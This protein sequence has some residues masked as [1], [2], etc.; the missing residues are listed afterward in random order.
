MTLKKEEGTL[1]DDVLFLPLLERR[2]WEE[3]LHAFLISVY[4]P[5]KSSVILTQL[6]PHKRKTATKVEEKTENR[7]CF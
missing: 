2:F 3:S 5:S 4:V 7:S 6:H 1:F